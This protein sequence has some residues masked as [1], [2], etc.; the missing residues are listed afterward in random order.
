MAPVARLKKS[1][2]AQIDKVENRGD[3][4]KLRYS[5]EVISGYYGLA[6]RKNKLPFGG[7]LVKL[8]L[9]MAPA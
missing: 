4:E 5:E 9:V 6:R 3:L 7:E 2:F 1:F 8:L